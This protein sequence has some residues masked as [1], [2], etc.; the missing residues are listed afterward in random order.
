[1]VFCL[2][3][4]CYNTRMY[5]LIFV[6]IF[7]LGSVIGSFL[8]VV[9]YRFNSGKTLG[10]RSICMSC[11]K[12]LSWYELVPVL[13]FIMQ[14]GKC[15]KCRSIISYQYPLVEISTGI[16]FALLAFHFLNI[17][18][19][20]QKTYVFLLGYFALLFSLLIV[21]AVY[22][23][24]H[25]IIPNKLSYIFAALTFLSLF[26]NH[27]GLGHLFVTPSFGSLI[28]GPLYAAPFALLWLGS[29]GKWMGLGDA[30]LILG[31]GWMLGLF[32]TLTA[33]TFSF[34]IGSVVSLLVMFVQSK[35]MNLKTEIP[36]A[37]F[38]IIGTLIV[39]LCNIDVFSLSTFFTF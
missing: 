21:I 24:R 17:L 25:K 2:V 28:A 33:L 18:F 9:I 26:I 10:G 12:T 30:K 20:S 23:M 34:W 37:P 13:S 38:L 6:F 11:N 16:I 19:Y 15:R 1:M 32:A 29:K 4:R 3:G 22:D 36:F 31:I 14:S 7:L 5:M 27:T 35:K 8:N 39:F